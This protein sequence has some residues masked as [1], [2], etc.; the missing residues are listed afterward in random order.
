MDARA[1]RDTRFEL[2]CSFEELEAWRDAAQKHRV[3]LARYVRVC[4]ENRPRLQQTR[5]ADPALIRQL[6]AFG[7][8]LN[9]ITR[10]ANA[11]QKGWQNLEPGKE[12][13]AQ[14]KKALGDIRN[15]LEGILQSQE[16]RE[17]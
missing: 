8:N 15:A 6:A 7:N 5:Q 12:E 2:R 14:I 1:K 13:I 10:W 4:L 16:G 9:Q 3:P 11:H 17:P